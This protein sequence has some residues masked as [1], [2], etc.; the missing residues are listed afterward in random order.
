VSALGNLYYMGDGM[1]M[2]D[3]QMEGSAEIANA[4]TQAK[5]E[6]FKEEHDVDLIRDTK[7][8]DVLDENG[9]TTGQKTVPAN[10]K[11]YFMD[12]E[13]KVK[14]SSPQYSYDGHAFWDYMLLDKNFNYNKF[15]DYQTQEANDNYNAVGNKYAYAINTIIPNIDVDD[16]VNKVTDRFISLLGE[17]RQDRNLTTQEIT[18]LARLKTVHE[19]DQWVLN[20]KRH[21]PSP[22][23]RPEIGGDNSQTVTSLVITEKPATNRIP[24]TLNLKNCI[25]RIQDDFDEDYMNSVE[26]TYVIFGVL[27]SDNLKI[28]KEPLARLY[29]SIATD[30]NG[31]KSWVYLDIPTDENFIPTGEGDYIIPTDFWNNATYPITIT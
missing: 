31:D 25:F 1:V 11:L 13:R 16:I 12:G 6:V 24:I 14:F 2:F 3:L 22:Y 9:E 27:N 10:D 8:I 30:A 28:R 26:N 20:K 21:Y 5:I 29:K 15:Q 4:W 19:D 23:Y 7:M 18:L 17:T